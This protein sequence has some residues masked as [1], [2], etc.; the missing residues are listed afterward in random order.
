VV[1]FDSASSIL[2]TRNS[3]SCLAVIYFVPTSD[4]PGIVRTI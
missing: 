4:F 1:S 2:V 3:A